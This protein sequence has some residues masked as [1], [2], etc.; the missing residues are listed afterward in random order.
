MAVSL[1]EKYFENDEFLKSI[2][3]GEDIMS[4]NKLK[5]L[6]AGLIDEAKK[7]EFDYEANRRLL[8]EL[9]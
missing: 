7:N 2:T 8:V 9:A 1:R 5:Q 6:A 3:S 4:L